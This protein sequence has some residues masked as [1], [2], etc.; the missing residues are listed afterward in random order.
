MPAPIVVVNGKGVIIMVN[1]LALEQFGYSTE[2]IIGQTIECLIPERFKGK[3]PM[4]LREFFS[5][6]EPRP[7]GSGRELFALRKDGTEFP[8]EIGLNP[9]FNNGEQLALT[10]IINIS[11]RKNAEQEL[12][13]YKHFFTAK[14]NDKM[15]VIIQAME[16]IVK[17]EKGKERLLRFFRIRRRN[18]SHLSI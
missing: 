4:L 3:H 11:E 18:I 1:A 16:H 2:E 10:S 7:M 12:H 15:I 5:S 13:L 8:V 17:Q 14:T 9:F 6:P